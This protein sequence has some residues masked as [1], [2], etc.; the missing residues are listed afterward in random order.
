MKIKI[1]A[2]ASKLR[3]AEYMCEGDQLDAIYK[4]FKAISAQI[5]LPEETLAW[6]AHIERVKLKYKKHTGQN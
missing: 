3:A 5:E 1:N 2:D 6:M 4:G